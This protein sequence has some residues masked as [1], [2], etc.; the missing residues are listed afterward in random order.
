MYHCG[1]MFFIAC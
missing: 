1:W